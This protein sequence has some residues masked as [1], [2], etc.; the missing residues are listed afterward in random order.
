[1]ISIV[2]V[3]FNGGIKV[4]K[5]VRSVLAQ[6]HRDYELI[7]VDNGSTDNSKDEIIQK[8]SGKIKLIELKKNFGFTKGCNLG[9]SESKGEY[10][11]FLN[12]D[13]YLSGKNFLVIAENILKKSKNNICGIFPKVFFNWEKNV[14]NSTY[15]IW[16]KDILWFDEHIGSVDP[17]LLSLDDQQ[18]EV[19]GAMFIAPIFKKSILESSGGF[20]EMLFTYGEDFDLSYRMNIYGYKFL[21]TPLIKVYHDYRSSSLDEIQPLWSYFYFLRNYLIVILKNY[22]LKNIIGKFSSYTYHFRVALK[23]SIKFK[24]WRKML[25]MLKILISLLFLAPL[26]IKKRLEIQ[27]KRKFNDVKIWSN[28]FVINYNPNF[29]N[30]HIVLNSG[31][32]TKIRK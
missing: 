9:I 20:D 23:H 30:S 3:N 18:K 32:V 4:V 2:I 1:M 12:N 25:L 8:F 15:A 14:L 19:F 5:S 31:N 21:Y 13:A 16:H 24:E 27:R 29:Y 26:I 10:I 28:E 17:E 7:V 6:A 22:E 11:M